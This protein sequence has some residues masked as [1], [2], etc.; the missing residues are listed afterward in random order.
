MSALDQNIN[1]AVGG[2]EL[3]DGDA[4]AGVHVFCGALVSRDSSGNFRPGRATNT[5]RVVG[6]APYEVDNTAGQ[7][8]DLTVRAV[9]RVGFFTNSADADEITAADLMNSCYVVND[10]TV[11][12]TSNSGARPIAGKI[13]GFEGGL[14][15]VD[16]G[17][18]DASDGDLVAANN[19][20]DVASAATARAN[21]G[22]NKG[23]IW[24]RGLALDSDPVLRAA[25]PACTITGWPCGMQA[26]FN[27]PRTLKNRP[28]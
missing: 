9:K 25:L 26:T 27:G 28:W 16:V 3:F 17:G 20:S 8:G 14:V 23:T 11:S 7:A 12:K 1:N 6:I 2:A 18:P 24:F 10:Q 4:A 21:I 13:L 19:L 15:R 5:D 22:A